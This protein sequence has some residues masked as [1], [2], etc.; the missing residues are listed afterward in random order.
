MSKSQPRNPATRGRPLWPP[1][2]M[3]GVFTTPEQKLMNPFD[4]WPR[5]VLLGLAIFAFFLLGPFLS[6]LLLILVVA[7][8]AANLVNPPLADDTP[9]NLQPRARPVRP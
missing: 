2:T 8:V 9:I 6:G 5:A 1:L 3:A 7:V 4:L